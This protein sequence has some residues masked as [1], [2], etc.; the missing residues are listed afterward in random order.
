MANFIECNS[1]T[2]P[3]LFWTLSITKHFFMPHLHTSFEIHKSAVVDYALNAATAT[4]VAESPF[5]LIIQV[6]V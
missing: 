3:P 6:T 2:P 1:L 4:A 5:H